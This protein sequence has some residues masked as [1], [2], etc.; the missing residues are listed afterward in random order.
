MRQAPQRKKKGR[1][2]RQFMV[3]TFLTHVLDHKFV[4]TR[5][6]NDAVC[7][8]YWMPPDGG[9][10][11]VFRLVHARASAS[12]GVGGTHH[13]AINAVLNKCDCA[14]IIGGKQCTGA[15]AP[16]HI[17]YNVAPCLFCG[18]DLAGT[19]CAI[20]ANLLLARHYA[21]NKWSLA[22]LAQL[23]PHLLRPAAW[24]PRAAQRHTNCVASGML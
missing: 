18:C 7:A 4:C 8:F 24:R 11:G 21:I 6:V 3:H 20:C 9:R 1:S 19:M 22:E 13:R 2:N 23:S 16:V 10:F 12:S 14:S 17:T 5:D 15:L